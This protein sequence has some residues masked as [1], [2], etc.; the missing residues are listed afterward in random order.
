MQAGFRGSG[1]YPFDPS[2]IHD[3]TLSPSFPL[4]PP[5][6]GQPDDSVISQC[7]AQKVQ[8]TNFTVPTVP[9]TPL[10]VYLRDHF[11]AVLQHSMIA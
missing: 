3:E 1:L 2:V 10:L 7:P 5:L 11:A 8:S 9:F 4:L 6:E